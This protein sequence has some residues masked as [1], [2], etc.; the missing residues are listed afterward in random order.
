VYNIIEKDRFSTGKKAAIIRVFA[1][2]QSGSHKMGRSPQ[3]SKPPPAVQSGSV[4]PYSLV[5][6]NVQ[7]P[8][9]SEIKKAAVEFG[10]VRVCP[11]RVL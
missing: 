10:S 7:K 6:K 2:V 5:V 4:P 9:N 8:S 3:N 1:P 11:R